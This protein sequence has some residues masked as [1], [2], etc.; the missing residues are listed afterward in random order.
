MSEIPTTIVGNVVSDVRSISTRSGATLSS[1]RLA[2][3]NRRFNRTTNTWVDL[4][5]TYVT[6][7]CWRLLA[8]HVLVSLRRGD[9]VLVIGRLRVREW[10]NEDKSGVVVE[11]EATSL[12]HDLTRGTSTFS[13]YRR[14]Q[15][16]EEEELSAIDPWTQENAERLVDLAAA[17]GVSVAAMDGELLDASA[18]IERKSA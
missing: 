13:R 18:D 3:N 11:I 5:T 6:V 1:F 7:N 9:P 10:S 14:E 16:D 4:D 2:A 15:T 17:A 12:G 8:D